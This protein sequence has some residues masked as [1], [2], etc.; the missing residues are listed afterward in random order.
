MISHNEIL[1]GDYDKYN[2]KINTI[3]LNDILSKIVILKNLLLS[4]RKRHLL[5]K[6]SYNSKVHEVV[7]S[8]KLESELYN[9]ICFAYEKDSA[10]ILLINQEYGKL[11][12]MLVSKVKHHL[13][14]RNYILATIYMSNFDDTYNMLKRNFR[15]KGDAID[16]GI[17]A[18]L[19][20]HSPFYFKSK[21]IDFPQ[22]MQ[23][24]LQELV[25]IL[26]FNEIY[27]AYYRFDVESK[28]KT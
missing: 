21:I 28:K 15:A 18:I 2:R 27:K 5:K 12:K 4:F 26:E 20:S 16:D 13:N 11:L 14:E 23:S 8:S 17:K 19:E 25:G 1:T 7:S 10:E 6:V 3:Y 22:G 24:D 9:K